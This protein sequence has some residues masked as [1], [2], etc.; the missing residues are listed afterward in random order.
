M[1]CVRQRRARPRADSRVQL[2]VYINIVNARNVRAARL[3]LYYRVVRGRVERN[4]VSLIRRESGVWAHRVYYV[5]KITIFVINV[6]A[7][8]TVG[9]LAFYA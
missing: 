5:I 9:G 2:D 8:I 4:A 3:L 1:T 6:I 7:Y